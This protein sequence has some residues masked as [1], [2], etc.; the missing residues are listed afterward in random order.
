MKS[1]LMATIEARRFLNDLVTMDVDGIAIYNCTGLNFD[2]AYLSSV[3][4]PQ[5]LTPLT[6]SD[7]LNTYYFDETTKE[8]QVRVTQASLDYNSILYIK[9]IINITDDLDFYYN[10]NPDDS[11]SRQV[12]YQSRIIGKPVFGQSQENNLN[13]QL[14]FTTSTLDLNNADRYFDQ[15]FTSDDSF[16]GCNIIAWRCRE[17][18]D[19]K[20]IVYKGTVSKIS[21]DDSIKFSFEDFLTRL[22]KVLY[23]MDSYSESVARGRGTVCEA[24][25]DLK[26]HRIYGRNSSFKYKFESVN[27]EIN[28]RVLDSSKMPQAFCIDYTP[29]LSKTVNRSWECGVVEDRQGMEEIY[30]VNNA[31]IVGTGSGTSTVAV[32]FVGGNLD[33]FSIGDTMQIAGA[34]YARV[35]KVTNNFVYL[36]PWDVI[37]NSGDTVKINKVSALVLSKGGIDYYLHYKKD[38]NVF[39]GTDEVLKVILNNNFEDNYG[40]AEIDPVS[41]RI[42]FKIRN[43]SDR[44][45]YKHGNQIKKILLSEFDASELNLTS[46][47]D[48]NTNLELDLCFMVPLLDSEFPTKRDII[49]RLLISAFGYIYLDED[50]K[51]AYANFM[52]IGSA[53]DISD[54]EIKKGSISHS[55]DYNDIYNAINFVNSQFS[56]NYT[57]ES[58]FAR[59][60]HD[61]TKVREYDNL[62]DIVS[63]NKPIDHFKAV[64]KILTQKRINTSLVLLD[65]LGTIGERKSIGASKKLGN[66]DSIILSLDES[67]QESMAGLTQLDNA[68]SLI[69]LTSNGVFLGDV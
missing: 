18:I 50:F 28:I 58:N 42:T 30:T 20:K 65:K 12:I 3:K 15:F 29:A 22:D 49:E 55:I 54:V 67:N 26:L 48:A 33:E 5:S 46:F 51:I 1:F 38:Y 9:H 31:F 66:L 64:A 41:D 37:I 10:Q 43:V 47:D 63:I 53:T 7:P 14:S 21:I 68:K 61:T 56:D 23:S 2:S 45:S 62:C 39:V 57:L 36:S 34:H 11:N 69:F 40:L 59:F 13:G 19:N 60:I 44:D 6:L 25:A 8:L 24:Q 4:C 52:A 17:S 32:D 16:K 27:D 35:V